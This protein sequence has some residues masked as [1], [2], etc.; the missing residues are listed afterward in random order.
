LS[1]RTVECVKAILLEEL[2]LSPFGGGAELFVCPAGPVGPQS[3]IWLQSPG[4]FMSS[5]YR[6]RLRGAGR[7]GLTGAVLRALGPLR[8]PMLQRFRHLRGQRRDLFAMTLTD[9]RGN[10]EWTSGKPE[11]ERLYCCHHADR[12]LCLADV[13]GDG[14]DEILAIYGPGR[15]G[16]FSLSDGALLKA[17]P[18]PSDNFAF[19]TA[20]RSG[21]A[22]GDVLI[23]VGVSEQAYP[24]HEYSNPFVLLDADL[25]IVAEHDVPAGI[26]HDAQVFDADGDGR[27]EFLAGYTLVDHDGKVLWTAEG[28]NGQDARPDAGASHADSIAILDRDK[29]RAWRAAIAG[30]DTT[31]MIDH[32]GR[33]LWKR[34]GPHPQCILHGCFDPQSS[35]GCLFVLHM[36]KKME[37]LSLAG[38][39]VWQG[40]LPANWPLGRPVSVPSDDCFHM[41]RPASTW[42]D[43]LGGGLDLIVYNEAGWPYAVDGFGRRR[44]EF[45]CPDSARQPAR[46]IPDWRPDDYGFGYHAVVTDVDADGCEEVVIHD[47]RRAWIYGVRE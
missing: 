3:F 14:R 28:L 37:T 43:P 12:L 13:N 22:A 29:P 30:S 4:V 33:L 46:E 7:K 42:H 8:L 40:K 32:E 21:P 11:A 27:D 18:L 41:S 38:R 31:Y 23:M 2:D 20:G 1:T 10:V 9:S 34:G 6:H 35:Q 45:P 5:L 44:V 19:V 25:N 16:V 36:R 24:P 47:R 15:L 26:G 17:R 39:Q